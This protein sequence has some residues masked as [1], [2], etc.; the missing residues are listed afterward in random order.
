MDERGEFISK[1]ENSDLTDPQ[2]AL[3]EI[4]TINNENGDYII[5]F[6]DFQHYINNPLVLRA[7]KDGFS[8]ATENGVC[9]VFISN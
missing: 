3:E 8:Y 6:L 4:R 7:A 5:C 2:F 9:I 1:A